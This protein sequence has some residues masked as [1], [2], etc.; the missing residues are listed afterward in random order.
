M[1]TPN[2]HFPK[3]F[4][5]LF[6]PSRYKVAWG[7]R[8]SGKS[9]NIARALLIMGTQRRLRILCAR[10]LQTSILESVHH[11]L[12]DQ[13]DQLGL[14]GWY[15]VQQQ[16]IAG[17]NGTEF[18]FSGIHSNPTKIKSTEGVDICWIEEA[19]KV[20]ARSWEIVIPT[21]RKTGSEIWVSFNPDEATDPT[22][23]RFVVNPPPDAAVR[24]VRWIDNPWF[25]EELKRE[26]DYLA[27]VDPAAYQHVWEGEC[28]SNSDAQ[29]F[30][31]KYRIEAFAVPIEP[32]ASGWD[33][34]Y[35]GADWGFSQDPTVLVKLWIH[36]RTLYIEREAYGIGVE[37]DD[38]PEL[39]RR[40]PD[41]D[42]YVIRA[43]SSRPETISHVKRKGPFRI[44]AAE[45][46]PGSVEDGIAFLRSFE[47]IV[48]HP[49]CRH[50]IEEARLYSYKVDRLTGDVLPDIVD[51][52]NHVWDSVRY[53]LGPMISN[54]GNLAIW[55]K[56]AQ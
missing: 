17:K 47:S 51:K 15:R 53:G 35:F 10:E 12:A 44:E 49:D 9:W 14:A 24:K 48:I 21:I 40:I 30:K 25:G 56:L 7:G 36:G 32:I 29:I 8:G 26:K 23:Q 16:N 34:P 31:G 52:H 42:R 33:G 1:E 54:V 41:V 46:W 45:K 43:D 28:R 37:L 22:Y 39:F 19:E 13:I 6:E 50:A 11:L 5:F 18:I 38:I 2:A 3:I 27:R 4:R 55:A 20:S